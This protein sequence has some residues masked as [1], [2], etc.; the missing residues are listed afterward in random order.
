MRQEH[1]AWRGR[2]AEW[3]R[4]TRL[5]KVTNTIAVSQTQIVYWKQKVVSVV[6]P[7][8]CSVKSHQRSLF[9]IM[10][11][12]VPRL[13][14]TRG[15]TSAVMALPVLTIRVSF[16]QNVN[17]RAKQTVWRSWSFPVPQMKSRDDCK[18]QAHSVSSPVPSHQVSLPVE[19]SVARN[20][21][22]QVTLPVEAPVVVPAEA[23][24]LPPLVSK[25]KVQLAAPLAAPAVFHPAR[26][27][28]AQAD[29]P[30][31]NPVHFRATV[32]ASNPVKPPLR[33]PL[34][35]RPLR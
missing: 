10:D 32:P 35:L 27:V 28:I 22:P 20:Q 24:L 6:H 9:A 13:S 23:P 26:Q 17:M 5:R 15:A 16:R 25:V 3:A 34:S 12:S 30:A 4:H 11:G 29:L 19:A 14:I 1:K 2:I 33:R 8:M 21:N 18:K 7:R 31:T